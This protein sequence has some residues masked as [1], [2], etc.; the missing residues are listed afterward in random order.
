MRKAARF[1]DHVRNSTHQV[2]SRSLIGV[3]KFDQ[4]ALNGKQRGGTHDDSLFE[5]SVGSRSKQSRSYWV[6]TSQNH[7]THS[8][9]VYD[10][11]SIMEG[12]QAMQLATETPYESRIESIKAT[13]LSEIP[14]TT[15]DYITLPKVSVA[16]PNESTQQQAV[17]VFS[18]QSSRSRQVAPG[19]IH[20]MDK[21]T[22]VDLLSDSARPRD[23]FKKIL[24]TANIADT[25]SGPWRLSRTID[26]SQI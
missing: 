18:K 2:R 17:S 13:K 19:K 5:A 8:I 25:N 11:I 15:N 14:K 22:L 26:T 9:R 1:A 20:L 16:S 10:K 3:Q 7:R 23:G 4:V 12:H 6:S 21:N 24:K